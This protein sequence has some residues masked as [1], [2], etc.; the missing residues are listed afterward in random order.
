[1][2]RTTTD[3]KWGEEIQIQALSIV[4]FQP[5]YSSVKFDNDPNNGHY[6]PSDI[7]IPKLIDRFDKGISGGRLNYIGYKSGMN[8]L[9][10]CIHFT[11]NHYDA[12]LPFIINMSL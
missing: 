11:G 3:E 8:K 9:S 7:S 6:I 2:E 5:I 4:L 12:L 1:M 10:L